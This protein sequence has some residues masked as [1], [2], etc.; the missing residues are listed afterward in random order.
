MQH[1]YL[2]QGILFSHDQQAQHDHTKKSTRILLEFLSACIPASAWFN[3]TGFCQEKAIPTLFPAC[4]YSALESPGP[5]SLHINTSISRGTGRL[6][7]LDGRKYPLPE[8]SAGNPSSNH[9]P[10]C[11]EKFCYHKI[12]QMGRVQSLLAAFQ[13]PGKQ[14]NPEKGAFPKFIST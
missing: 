4:V 12:P 13:R 3:L 9:Q 10:C 1:C 5:T 8:F 14:L 6:S 7:A 2:I 11:G